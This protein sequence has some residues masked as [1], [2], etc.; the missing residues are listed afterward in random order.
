[1]RRALE[2]VADTGS[3]LELR[4]SFGRAMI[5]ALARIE[6][7]PLGVIANDPR[8]FVG[9][10]DSDAADKS[11]RFMQLCDAH[12]L[13]ILFFCDTPGNMVGPEAERTGLV[14]HVCRLYVTGANPS[15]PF[16]TVI[17]RKGYGLGSQAMAGGGFHNPLFTVAWPTGEFGA[18]GLEGAVKLGFRKE[19]EAIADDG[20][21]EAALR[22][23]VAAAYEI[24][25]GL[26]A[27]A[28]GEI[29][30][31]I[32]PA[33]TRRWVTASVDTPLR[34]RPAGKRR[35]FVDTW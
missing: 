18:M 12:G 11:A 26:N 3:V 13:P 33:E 24:G 1:M 35:A 27:A 6:G 30:D 31:V 9:A 23:R 16:F 20:E 34:E 32:D 8:V 28:F 22:A 14:R 7:R 21:R 25:R 29:D 17:T 15:V 10:I 4:R 2:L 5:T 19:L